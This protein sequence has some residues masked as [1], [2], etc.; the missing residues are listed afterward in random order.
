M[1][2]KEHALQ[3][4]RAFLHHRVIVGALS[5]L[6][7]L[8][9]SAAFGRRNRQMKCARCHRIGRSN[10][11]SKVVRRTHF[12]STLKR[13]NTPARNRAEEY[14]CRRIL[15]APDGR[16]V[17]EMDDQGGRL[18]REACLAS[19]RRAARIGSKSR[20]KGRLINRVVI[21]S[22]LAEVRLSTSDDANDSDANML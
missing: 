11:K 2:S 4:E 12:K 3:A 22:K 6:L 1:W 10:A 18:W 16:L 14:C 19:R 7:G 20:L 5:L 8:T 17:V 9:A 13:E 21:R 15:F